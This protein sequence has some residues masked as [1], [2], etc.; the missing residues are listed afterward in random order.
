MG[1]LSSSLRLRTKRYSRPFKR[2]ETPCLYLVL[3]IN[4]YNIH[5]TKIRG[6]GSSAGLT[7][8]KSQTSS[9]WNLIWAKLKR[10][11]VHLTTLDSLAGK[12]WSRTSNYSQVKIRLRLYQTKTFTV[13]M[14]TKKVRLST[15][16]RYK[17]MLQTKMG[18]LSLHLIKVIE[19]K[20]VWVL[21]IRRFPSN[22]PP[23]LSNCQPL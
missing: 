22:R 11:E 21:S 18:L 4:V 3:Q 15:W 7:L 19:A 23:K 14:K 5:Q 12:T 10:Q 9:R 20:W 6:T 16:T 1:C 13:A 2:N 8:L 17:C